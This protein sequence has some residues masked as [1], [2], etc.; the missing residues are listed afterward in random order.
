MAGVLQFQWT[1]NRPN[2]QLIFPVLSTLAA[3][4]SNGSYQLSFNQH[5]LTTWF[6]EIRWHRLASTCWNGDGNEMML[7]LSKWR[8]VQE[9]AQQR[10]ALQSPMER[11]AQ[12]SSFV[13]LYF[14][15][16][17]WFASDWEQSQSS[18][19]IASSEI[20]TSETV[21]RFTP[22][23]QRV[24]SSLASQFSFLQLEMVLIKYAEW[25]WKKKRFRCATSFAC[26]Y[27]LFGRSSIDGN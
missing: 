5:R 24:S 16:G 22:L 4:I 21:S 6:M 1:I 10:A 7:W 3:A 8:K 15:P 2:K 11:G 25:I 20:I 19:I 14:L 27:S 17:L 9:V 12:R 13:C 18:T 26:W 23:L